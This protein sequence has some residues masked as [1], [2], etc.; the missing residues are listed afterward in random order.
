MSEDYF[1]SNKF[2]E[3]EAA[4][5]SYEHT[6]NE[7]IGV[8]SN[9]VWVPLSYIQSLRKLHE[10]VSNQVKFILNMDYREYTS[11]QKLRLFNI[12]NYDLDYNELENVFLHQTKAD[13]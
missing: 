9:L 4:L 7:L 3:L 12:V 8:T 6:F 5:H 2:G 10:D 13:L 11:R 1:I